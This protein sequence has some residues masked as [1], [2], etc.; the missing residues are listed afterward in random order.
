MCV[1]YDWDV[2]DNQNESCESYRN[3]PEMCASSDLNDDE[4]FKSSE[5]CCVCGGGC[6]PSDD[7]DC[8]RNVKYKI[9]LEIYFLLSVPS[10]I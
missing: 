6:V 9:I 4:D 5:L 1:D 8:S 10:R 3:S 2:F 7:N